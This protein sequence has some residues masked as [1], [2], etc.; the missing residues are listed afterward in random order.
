[1]SIRH[2]NAVWSA[3]VGDSQA[4]IVLLKLADCADKDGLCWPSLTVI[5]ADTEM[6][7]ATVCRKID[8]L[9]NLGWITRNRIKNGCEY[10]V[11]L[12]ANQSHTATTLESATSRTQ[13]LVAQCDQSHTATQLVAGCDTTSRTARLTY[14]REPS[15]TTMEPPLKSDSAEQALKIIDAYPR[16]EKIALALGIVRKDLDDGESF[17]E[18]LAKTKAISAVIRSLPSGASNRYVPSAETFFRDKRWQDD[19]GSFSRIDHAPPTNGHGKTT[20][21]ANYGI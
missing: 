7:R 18:I 10:T 4:K 17:D 2:I 8:L 20:S 13:Q 11:N 1:M 9:E 15:G 3:H 12:N 14:T 21:A 19:P 6:H 16:K 5:A